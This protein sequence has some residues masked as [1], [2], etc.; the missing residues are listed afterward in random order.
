M[1]WLW[2]QAEWNSCTDLKSLFSYF[3][4]QVFLSSISLLMWCPHFLFTQR[5]KTVSECHPCWT[6]LRAE[7]DETSPRVSDVNHILLE[8]H[9]GGCMTYCT[10]FVYIVIHIWHLSYSGS[11]KWPKL[12]SIVSLIYLSNGDCSYCHTFS[13]FPYSAPFTLTYIYIQLLPWGE[14]NSI[15]HSISDTRPA[16]LL[17]IKAAA[18]RSCLKN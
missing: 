11:R 7:H 12:T 10:Q 5:I 13:L 16:P 18:H 17:Y 6:Y 3:I 1:A 8:T 9:P 2:K 4:S 14:L 15:Q